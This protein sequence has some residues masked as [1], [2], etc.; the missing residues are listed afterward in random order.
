MLLGTID[1]DWQ[2]FT[3]IVYQNHLEIPKTF[4]L[5]LNLFNILFILL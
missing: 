1:E 2:F 4:L 3:L 5:Q